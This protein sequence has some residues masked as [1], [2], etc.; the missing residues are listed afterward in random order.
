MQADVAGLVR[1]I[2]GRRSTAVKQPR[3]EAGGGMRSA[4]MWG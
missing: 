1:T 4:L 2:F 3:S